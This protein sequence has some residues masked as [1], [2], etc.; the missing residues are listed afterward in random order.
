M[1]AGI[2]KPLMRMYSYHA[3]TRVVFGLGSFDRLKDELKRFEFKRALL[4]TGKTV[5]KTDACEKVREVI[6]SLGRLDEFN[7]VTPEPDSSV[8][9]LILK[10]VKRNLPELVVGMGGGSSM[11]I[12]KMAS[13]LIVNEKDPISYFKGEEITKKGPP[14]LTIPTIAG[15]G[16]E[17]NP[18][19]VIVEKGLKLALHHY[20]I[21]PAVTIIDPALSVTASPHATASAGIDALCHAVESIMSVDSNPITGSLSYEAISLVDDFI[22]RAY[23]NG[24][25]IE[26]RNG[27]ALASVMAG[28]AFANTGLCLAHGI[29]YTYATRCKLPHGASVGVAEPYVVE[30]NSPAIPDKVEAIA[31]GLGI[32]TTGLSTY[33]IGYHIALRIADLMDTLDLPL[34]LEELKLEESDIEPMV[35]DLLTNYSRF[36]T[37]NP[38]KPTKEDLML[39]Y[40]IMFDGL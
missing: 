32:D 34:S 5:C 9:G 38:R 3:P 4:V 13:L 35:D 14:I 33:E 30:F 8:L 40:K 23:C 12:A 15:T 21:Y 29:A 24:E 26:A 19:S 37:K 2:Y 39:L 10:V 18:I 11:D 16:S 17:V 31:A 36:L 6:S 20:F 28:M 22:E 7:A 1:D 27:L 25:D